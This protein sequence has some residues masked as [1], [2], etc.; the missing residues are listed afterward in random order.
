MI[1]MRNADTNSMETIR[2]ALTFDQ[3]INLAAGQTVAGCD[4]RNPEIEH[5]INGSR[6]KGDIG[7]IIEGE[8]VPLEIDGAPLERYVL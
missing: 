8:I 6:V 3:L 7:A 1:W 5:T 2:V 4:Q